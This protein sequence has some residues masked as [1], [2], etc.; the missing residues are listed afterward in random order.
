VGLVY[1]AVRILL[2]GMVGAV[3][4]WEVHGREHVPPT[5]GL[6]VASNHI[7][8]Y[9][10]PFIGTALVRELHYL[11][12]EELFRQPVLGPLITYF[13]SIPIRR[14]MADLSGLHRAMECLKAGNALIVFPEGSRMR[15]GELHPGRPGVGMLA[16]NT[17][18]M[19]LPCFI[20]GSDRPNQW[21]WKRGTLGVSFGPARTWR[22]YAG[23]AAGETAGRALYQSVAD[24]VMRD[25]AAL[26]AQRL[27]RASRG[28]A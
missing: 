1:S 24:G 26:K 6:I 13:N 5:G 28:A 14:G 3:S 27:K 18:A 11:A 17:D 7:S 22:D 4:G 8:F 19:I 15:D 25:I 16:V 10:P 2:D 23:G 12:K 9:D 21:I 20:S